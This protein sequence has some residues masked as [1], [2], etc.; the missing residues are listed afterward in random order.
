MTV[1]ARPMPRPV[2]YVAIP[3]PPPILHRPVTATLQLMEF[4]G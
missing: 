1:E 3:D 4:E 2:E